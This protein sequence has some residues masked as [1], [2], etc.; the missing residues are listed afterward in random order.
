MM[1]SQN[2]KRRSDRTLTEVRFTGNEPPIS[3]SSD[4]DDLLVTGFCKINR[5]YIDKMG[6]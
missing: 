4:R 1:V 6:R 2:E 5:G 3:D